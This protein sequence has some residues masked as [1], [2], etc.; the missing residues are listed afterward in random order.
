[1]TL[2]NTGSTQDVGMFEM[3]HEA[4]ARSRRLLAVRDRQRPDRSRSRQTPSDPLS[5]VGGP[6]SDDFNSPSLLPKWALRHD[7][8]RPITQ[9]G[10]A[11]N[12]PVTTGDINEASTGPVSFA[13]QPLP[14]GN[15]TATT[16]ITLA[17]T[18]HWQ[19]AGLVVHKSDNEYNKIG[20]VAATAR[21]T[22][23]S[24]SSPRPTARAPRRGPRHCRRTSRRRST[25]G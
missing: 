3:S 10:G 2:A 4:A 5:C 6:L 22:G 17:H 9:S 19:W 25:S 11:L 12:L 15:W 21:P 20:F 24:S 18:S 8:A 14:A 1:M 7:P 13:G 23:S 16:K